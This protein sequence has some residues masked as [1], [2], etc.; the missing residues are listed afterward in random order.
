MGCSVGIE[1]DEGVTLGLPCSVAAS[2]VLDERPGPGLRR[3]VVDPCL[4]PAQ[5]T[6]CWDPQSHWRASRADM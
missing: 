1:H 6:C 3:G 4:L 5:P 2:V